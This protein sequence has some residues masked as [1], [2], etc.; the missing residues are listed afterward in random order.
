MS[1]VR[2]F[3][4]MRTRHPRKFFNL[5]WCSQRLMSLSSTY[6]SISSLD[7]ISQLISPEVVGGRSSS[8]PLTRGSSRFQR[9]LA[10]RSIAELEDCSVSF[11]LVCAPQSLA[12]GGN[13]STNDRGEEWLPVVTCPPP[14]GAST[15]MAS[16]PA[17]GGDLST[18]GSAFLPLS[19]RLRSTSSSSAPSRGVKVTRGAGVNVNPRGAG[20]AGVKINP[21]GEDLLDADPL[22]AARRRTPPG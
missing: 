16:P 17:S 12:S 3:H 18:G 22:D 20:G 11:E 6:F 5:W 1:F 21:R 14:L 19:L 9:R 4:H 7:N 15:S 8:S 13:L 2:K 10:V